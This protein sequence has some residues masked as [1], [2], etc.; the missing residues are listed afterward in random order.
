MSAYFYV[1]AL[2]YAMLSVWPRFAGLTAD[3]VLAYRLGAILF[4]AI[5]VWVLLR[6]PESAPGARLAPPRKVVAWVLLVV[7]LCAAV[8]YRVSAIRRVAPIGQLNADMLATI[9]TA[10][11]DLLRGENPYRGPAVRESDRF[12]PYLPALWLP[13]LPAVW[14][15]FDL[16]YLSLVTVLA[17]GL[18]LALAP[19][20]SSMAR[21]DAPPSWEQLA[22]AGCLWLAPNAVW[23][24][25]YGAHT[26]FYWLYLVGLLWSFTR[27]QW[28]AAGLWLGLCVASRQIFLG[29]LPIVLIYAWKRLDRRA[30]TS[31]FGTSLLVVVLCLA[32]FGLQGLRYL[33]QVVGPAYV[34][35]AEELWNGPQSWLITHSFGLS[36]FF[37]AWGIPQALPF[38]GLALLLFISLGGWFRITDVHSCVRFLA[39]SLLAATISVGTPVR[40]EFIP[41]VI[42][43]S[44]L[45]VV[46]KEERAE[47]TVPL[48]YPAADR[49]GVGR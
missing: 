42:V 7:L 43:L 6:D 24:G 14:L 10:L 15:N 5:N 17:V 23:F 11:E 16:R 26:H 18:L 9:Q 27:H 41:F 31:L 30:W 21:A 34:H 39:L 38:A 1:I 12:L 28:L 37:F 19:W 48:S 3:P 45:A 33:L 29:V 22:L 40:Y 46:R 20:R 47:I 32:P 13:Y 35:F 44:V 36:S 25:A 4:V 8:A 2:D 49:A